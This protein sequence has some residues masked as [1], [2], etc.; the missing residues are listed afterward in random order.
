MKE[1]KPITDNVWIVGSNGQLG[2][3]FARVITEFT[4]NFVLSDI[5]TVDITDYVAVAEF[6]KRNKITAIINCAAY[7]NVDQAE[8]DT[9]TAYD[10]NVMGVRNLLTTKCKLIHFSTDYVYSDNATS[11]ITEEFELSPLNYYGFTKRISEKFIDSVFLD[12]DIPAYA[13]LRISNLWSSHLS[14]R[15]NIITKLTDNII[16]NKEVTAFTDCY[17]RPTHA[18]TLVFHVLIDILPHL[19]PENSGIYNYSNTG[20]IMNVYNIAMTIANKLGI[21]KLVRKIKPVL[22]SDVLTK[23]NANRPKYTILD[24]SKI[25]KTFDISIPT[26]EKTV[27][28]YLQNRR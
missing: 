4:D 1:C 14:A 2:Q 10:I 18:E 7:T 17:F 3:A 13:V 27:E 9:K 11:P 19:S 15:A 20:E 5:D 21:S 26:W 25:E 24:V 6:V 28:V 16:N 12:N 8:V 23:R 22:S